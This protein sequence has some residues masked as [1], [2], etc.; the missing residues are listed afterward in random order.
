MIVGPALQ[1]NIFD[2][3]R[4]E[5]NVRVQD[6]RLQQLIEAYQD[7]VLQAAREV[8]DAAYSIQKTAEQQVLVDAAVQAS[9][10]ALEIANTRYREGYADFQRVLDAQRAMFAQAERQLTTQ[11][12]HIAGVINLYKGLGGGWIETPVEQLIPEDVRE[13]MQNRSDWGDLLTAPLSEPQ[14][15]SVSDQESS[16]DE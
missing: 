12:N 9:E 14:A 1:W 7:S 5:N 15:N 4:I 16:Q 2:Y 11:G 8:D 6:A 13:T 10:R 3:G